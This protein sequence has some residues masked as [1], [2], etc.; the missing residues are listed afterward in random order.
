M[1]RKVLIA[2]DHQSA[3]ISIRKAL[4]ELGIAEKD[5]RYYCDEAAYLF[6]EALKK[7]E[8]YDLLITDLSFDEDHNIQQIKSGKALIATV[9]SLQPSL[10]IIVFS[11]E[12]DSELIHDLFGDLNIDAYVLKARYDVDDLKRAINAVWANKKYRS[13]QLSSYAQKQHA[14]EFTSFDVKV[15][16]LLSEGVLQKNIPNVLKQQNIKPSGLSSIEKRLGLIKIALG[17]ASNEQLIA[18]CK[19]KRII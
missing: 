12:N 5:H 3:N 9:R 16:S 10:K 6:K 18:Y 13:V 11:V 14:Y 7:G 15:I 8:P 17:I 19:D 2:E 4:D 1:F